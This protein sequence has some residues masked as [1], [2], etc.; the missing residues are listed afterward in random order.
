[1]IGQDLTAA[2]RQ[3]QDPNISSFAKAQR[4][5]DYL[6]LAGRVQVYLRE[7]TARGQ[8]VPIHFE[9]NSVVE[10]KSVDRMR[11]HFTLRAKGVNNKEVD[12]PLLNIK[13]IG[14]VSRFPA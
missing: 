3:Y 13:R 9:D 2:V 8:I 1:M 5:E 7:Q 4:F 14:A 10:V 12:I 6:N 11:T